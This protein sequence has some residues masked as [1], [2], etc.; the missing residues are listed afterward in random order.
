MSLLGF[1]KSISNTT[2]FCLCELLINYC[3]NITCENYGIC[4]R[5][6]LNCSCECL[7]GSYSG[8]HCELTTRRINIFQIIARSFAYAVIIAI[9]S[10]AMFVM[11]M[12]ML[13]YCFGIDPIKKNRKRI[14]KAK[15]RK[16]HKPIIHRFV[17]V[18][19]STTPKESFQ[20]SF[21]NLRRLFTRWRLFNP[22]SHTMSRVSV[23]SQENCSIRKIIALCFF[24]TDY[25]QKFNYQL[26]SKHISV[27]D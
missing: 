4:R 2:Y 1:C 23:F 11:I 12:D 17:Y 8:R 26:F 21:G 19:A 18:N 5:S 14:R 22:K 10:V 27:S 6:L 7:S 15:R 24:L 20:N 25:V 16:K 9:I 3:Q 13:K